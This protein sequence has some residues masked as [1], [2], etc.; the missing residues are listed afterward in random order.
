MVETV[1]PDARH[2]PRP[3]WDAVGES[4]PG[5]PREARWDPCSGPRSEEGMVALS[6]TCKAVDP[7]TLSAGTRRTLETAMALTPLVVF[8]PLHLSTTIASTAGHRKRL[9]ADI[10][11]H[12]RG[13]S[14]LFPTER[15]AGSESDTLAAAP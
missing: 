12:A 10:D 6:S 3:I 4:V 9:A 13:F 15:A 5:Y 14:E 1:L 11:V 7:G 8:V 2:R